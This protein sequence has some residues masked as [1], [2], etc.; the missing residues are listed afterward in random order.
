MAKAED[1]RGVEGESSRDASAVVEGTL[2]EHKAM[3]QTS[4]VLD[5]ALSI[6]RDAERTDDF[7][8]GFSLGEALRQESA[9]IGTADGGAD[10]FVGNRRTRLGRLSLMSDLVELAIDRALSFTEQEGP[11]LQSEE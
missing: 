10:E 4:E 9:L 2:A 11:K 8:N 7:Y 3:L 6:L 5:E 1:V